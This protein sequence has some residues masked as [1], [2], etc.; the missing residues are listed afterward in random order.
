MSTF[1]AYERLGAEEAHAAAAAKDP[2]FAWLYGSEF[3]ARAA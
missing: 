2:S 3:P 1:A